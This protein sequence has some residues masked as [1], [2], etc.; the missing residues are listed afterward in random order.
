MTVL[1]QLIAELLEDA[2]KAHQYTEADKPEL[3]IEGLKRIRQC[4]NELDYMINGLDTRRSLSG[5]MSQCEKIKYSFNCVQRIV[6]ELDDENLIETRNNELNEL[7]KRK[8]I[9]SLKKSI[10]TA[11]EEAIDDTTKSIMRGE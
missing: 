4:V 6:Y 7:H 2:P 1:N 11:I 10:D 5:Y 3:I 9:R 8:V